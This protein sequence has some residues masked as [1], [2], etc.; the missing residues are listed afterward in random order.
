MKF[1]EF[2]GDPALEPSARA[3]D[4]SADFRV[5]RRLPR[6]EELWVTSMPARQPAIRLAVIDSETTGLGEHDKM[7]EFAMVK[8]ALD[9]DGQLCEVGAPIEGLEDPGAPLRPEIAAITG[10]DDTLLTDKRFD[11]HVL[12]DQLAD[13][14]AIIAFNMAFDAR[15]WRTRFPWITH[16]LICAQKDID[17]LAQG[18]SERSQTALLAARGFF[19]EAHRAAPDA[20]ALTILLATQ[21]RDGRTIAANLVDGAQRT[22]YRVRAIGAPFDCR[23]ALKAAGYRWDARA[24]TWWIDVEP[25]RLKAELAMLTDLHPS[26]R[27]NH[28]PLDWFNRH[29]G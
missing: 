5:L 10:L 29:I 16:P 22:T 8:I 6:L 13:V 19:Y 2:E 4:R 18:H 15:F 26:I 24:R 23:D 12:R 14:D 9:P 21:A 25:T 27:P 17:W 1:Y 3:L 7:V 11:E 20:W 28:Q